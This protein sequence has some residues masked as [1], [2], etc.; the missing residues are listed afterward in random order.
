[1]PDDVSIFLDPGLAL[2]DKNELPAYFPLLNQDPAFLHLDL[3]CM[4]SDFSQVALAKVA[5]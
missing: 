2:D 5:E 3:V 1:L 4:F